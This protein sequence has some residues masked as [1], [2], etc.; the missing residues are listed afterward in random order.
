MKQ[1]DFQRQRAENRAKLAEDRADK[2]ESML[3]QKIME[4][5]KLQGTLTHQT[6]VCDGK[7]L[8]GGGGA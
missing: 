7:T 5:S 4:L 3:N 2:N 6:K 8:G 1:L